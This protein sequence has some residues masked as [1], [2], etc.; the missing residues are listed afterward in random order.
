MSSK[1]VIVIQKAEENNLKQLSLEIPKHKI[2]VFTGV[3][4]SGKSSLVFDTIAAESQRLLNETYSTYIQ[5]QLPHYGRPKVEKIENLPVSIVIDQK[6]IGGNARSTVGTITD[7]LSYIRLLYSRIGKPF[8]GY[9]NIFSFNHPEGMCPHCNGLGEKEDVDIDALI[10]FNKSLNAGAIQFPT[11]QPGGWRWTRYVN[12]GL[13]D[14]DKK[15]KDYSPN[16]L[17]LLLYEKSKTLKS[18]PKEWHKTAKYEGVIIRIQK[19][20]LWKESKGK[21]TYQKELKRIVQK[22]ACSYCNGTRYNDKILSCKINGLSIGELCKL[23]IVD[24][25][26]FVEAIDSSTTE[27]VVSEITKRLETLIEV[28]LGYLSLDRSTSTLSGGESQRIKMVRHLNSSLSDIVYIFDEPSVG[29]HPEDVSRMNKLLL[30]IRDKGNTVLVVEH[31]PDMIKIADEIIDIGP[32]SGIEGGNIVF[33][34]SYSALLK[35]DTITGKTLRKPFIINEAPRIG[36]EFM[37]INDAGSHNLKHLSVQIPKHALTVITGV[38]GSGKSTLISKELMSRYSDI[39][40]LNQKRIHTTV[41][42]NLATYMGFYDEIRRLFGK[43]FNISSALFSYNSKGACE[44]CNGLGKVKTDLAFMD[45]VELV[46]E[47]CNGRRFKPEVL[48]YYINDK[49]IDDVLLLTVDEAISFLKG[50]RE[51][52]NRLSILQKVGLGY[53]QLGQSLDTFSGGEIQRLKLATKLNSKED[54]SIVVFDEP[55]TGLHESDIQNLLILFNNLIDEGNT[56]ILI[57]HNLSLISQADWVIDLG[58]EAGEKGG[59]L[60]YEGT[61]KGLLECKR[62]VTAKH[63]LKHLADN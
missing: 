4:G 19:A 10:D 2:T 58:P 21:K 45:D 23:S 59:Y 38:A 37:V 25:L 7:L 12:S 51:L 47:V 18:P 31:D 54:K 50:E 22:Q 56:V 5:N 35:S 46:C 16:E 48:E 33:K 30:A 53:I 13:F 1:D 43:Y 39:V 49:N 44:N 36:K 17:N 57:E 34:G 32:F 24:C 52:V 27:T 15:I 11:F 20:F 29:L 8:I 61:I 3:S 9:S 6:R 28:G 63:L 42:S 62:S 60:L 40:W 55:S 41:R 26:K 14:N